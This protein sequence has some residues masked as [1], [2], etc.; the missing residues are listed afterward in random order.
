MA[1][2]RKSERHRA[3]RAHGT[4]GPKTEA[5]FGDAEQHSA[6]SRTELEV[7]ELVRLFLREVFVSYFHISSGVTP[8]SIASERSR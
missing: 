8:N 1:I 7:N 5:I 6:V 4:N 3:V 2:K